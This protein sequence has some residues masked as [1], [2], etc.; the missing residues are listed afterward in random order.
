MWNR[1]TIQSVQITAAEDVGIEGRAGYYERGRRLRDLVQ[2]H[3]APA[4]CA[5]AAMEPPADFEADEVRNEKVKVLRAI[6]PPSERADA[7]RA[8]SP[9]VRGVIAGELVVRLPEEAGVPADLRTETHV[10][11]RL[12]VENWRWAGVPFYLRTGKR[13]P[14]KLTEIAIQMRRFRTWP[15]AGGRGRHPAEP[16][17]PD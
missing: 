4:A 7:I 2:N 14:R 9:P 15:S 8:R 1:N 17:D 5:A 11:L 13:L 10:A 6:R 3:S 12:E 16:A